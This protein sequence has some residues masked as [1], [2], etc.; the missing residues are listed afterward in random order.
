MI[1][2]YLVLLHWHPGPGS[3]QVFPQSMAIG[4]VV[5]VVAAYILIAALCARDRINSRSHTT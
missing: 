1:V 5:F 4:H 3:L 2:Y